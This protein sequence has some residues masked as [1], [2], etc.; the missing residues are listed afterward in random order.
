MKQRLISV[1]CWVVGLLVCPMVALAQD[2]P[3]QIDAKL[4]GYGKSV[5]VGDAS[6]TLMWGLFILLAAVC[7]AVLF[8]DAKRS[9]LD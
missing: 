9:H 8:K 2:E 7:I 6:S 5:R 4:E 3:L 1:W